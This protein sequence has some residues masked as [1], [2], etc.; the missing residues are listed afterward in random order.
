VA[1]VV[2]QIPVA[3]PAV[4]PGHPIAAVHEAIAVPIEAL[5]GITKYHATATDAPQNSSSTA[6]AW[7]GV[8]DIKLIASA[9]S[10]ERNLNFFMSIIILS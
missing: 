10:I 8:I 3:N 9:K 7:V 1:I 5:Q 2:A 6:L 4:H